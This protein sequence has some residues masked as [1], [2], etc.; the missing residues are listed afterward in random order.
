MKEFVLFAQRGK[1][2]SVCL[3]SVLLRLPI[4]SSFMYI[5][6]PL[7]ML[8]TSPEIKVILFHREI[9]YLHKCKTHLGGRFSD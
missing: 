7:N 4:M 8:I 1:K 3:G 5:S 6:G 9:R 2:E